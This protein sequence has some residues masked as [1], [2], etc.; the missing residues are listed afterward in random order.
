[1][2]KTIVSFCDG[3]AHTLAVRSVKTAMTLRVSAIAR[4]LS[5]SVKAAVTLSVRMLFRAPTKH[6]GEGCQQSASSSF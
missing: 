3:R 4:R 1:M 2:H 6:A 5:R